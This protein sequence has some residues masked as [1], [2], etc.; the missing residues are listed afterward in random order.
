MENTTYDEAYNFL[1]ET[2][3]QF[4]LE[5][6]DS[7]IKYKG[8]LGMYPYESVYTSVVFSEEWQG[9][10]HVYSING[11]SH[12]IN[13]MITILSLSHLYTKAN[14]SVAYCLNYFRKL[15]DRSLSHIS[16]KQVMGSSSEQS[17]SEYD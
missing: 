4:T 6:S 11:E 13:P 16:S 17:Y 3:P 1:I 7:D 14:K 2:I 9:K 8:V 12:Y 5:L 15:N 10:G